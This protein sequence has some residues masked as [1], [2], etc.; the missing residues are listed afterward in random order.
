MHSSCEAVAFA[1][2]ILDVSCWLPGTS[3][4]CQVR[5]RAESGLC[6]IHGEEMVSSLPGG[7]ALIFLE[8]GSREIVREG[9]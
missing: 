6:V 7:L 9:N 5:V 2:R 3:L 8:V 4:C 1:W